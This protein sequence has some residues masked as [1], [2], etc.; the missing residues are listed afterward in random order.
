MAR[1][2][3]SDVLDRLCHLSD[4]QATAG[5]MDRQL[6]ERFIAER[7]ADA[8][9]AL[10]QRH[11]PMVFGVCRRLLREPH[12][13]EDAFQAT[14]LV[15][16]R[17]AA[18]IRK[19]ESV[20]SWLHGVA[21]YVASK[22][23]VEAVRRSRRER[24]RRVPEVAENADSLTWDELR[25]VLDE[26]LGRLSASLRAPLVL[27]YL[28]GQTQD[29]AAR[30]LGWSK[31]TLRRRLERGRRLLR[32]RLAGRGV[33]LSAGLLA[34]LLS[35]PAV[36]PRTLTAGTVKTALAFGNGQVLGTGIPA[37]PVLLAKAALR[38]MVLTKI[39]VTAGAALMLSVLAA[40]GLGAL[41]AAVEKPPVA[42][43]TEAPSSGPD[44]A[45]AKPAPA[46]G[47]PV[48]AFGDPLP[49][50]ALARL[51][52]VRLRHGATPFAIDFS[53][54]GQALASAE[55]DGGVHI[56]ETATGKELLWI[57]NEDVPGG[58][59]AVLGLAYA[60]D[61]KTLA[62]ARMNQPPCLWDVAT[63]KEIRQF[64]GNQ[65]RA[66][67][68]VFS[69][70][71]QSLAYGEG[72]DNSIVRLAEV[73]TGK[74]QHQ[75]QGLKGF[76]PRPAFT[77][78][79]QT[80][81]LADDE[82]IHFFDLATERSQDLPQPD[83]GK[84]AFGCLV[85]SP[86]GKTLAAVSAAKKSIRFVDV[87]T[88]KTLRTIA[89]TGKREQVCGI[90]F[91]PD[92]KTLISG[93]E[94]GFVRFWDMASG[95]KT[96]QFRAHYY[97]VVRLALSRD[98][99]TLATSCN[100]HIGGDHTV[101]LWETATGKSLVRYPGPD[102]GIARLVFSPDSR[103]VATASWE[104][105]V[106]LWEAASGRSLRRWE[107]FGALAF[108]ADGMT[109]IC[110]GWEDGKVHF[111]DLATG[112]ET[113]HF[114]GH[115]KG[116]RDLCLSR[117]GKLL[118]TAAMDQ[119]LRLWDLATGRQ[120][121]DFGGKQKAAVLHVV[122]SP[123]G[124]LLASSYSDHVVR[125]WET[126]SGK[127]VREHV[128]ADDL[129]GLAISPDGQ[130]LAWS[131]SDAPGESSI[132]VRDVATGKEVSRLRGYGD[133]LSS[134]AF[135]PDG[136]S[137]IWGGQHR[138]EMCLF[139]VATGQ[140]R[141]KF[142]GHQGHV[143]CVAFAPN[144]RLMASGG[145]DTCVLIWAAA[146]QRQQLAPAPLREADLD[147][148]WADLAANDAATA[149]RAICTLR[150]SPRQTVRLLE[151]HLKPVPAADAKR[152]AQA[153]HDLDSD[154]FPIRDRA[155]QALA[156]LGEAAEPG[157]RQ[158]LAGKPSA[159][160]RRRVEEF[161]AQVEASAEG[162]RARA[163]EILEQIDSAD[164]RRLLSALAHGAPG[165]RLTREAQAALDRS[166]H[167]SE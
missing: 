164:S 90:V 60:P 120:L 5:M 111:L 84:G 108:T 10:V 97:T 39:K 1:P 24:Q 123:D 44:R 129:G 110:G 166:G 21:G 27:C 66:S 103:Q 13:A 94:D 77:P 150:A 23:R 142:S 52:T 67:W 152:V 76:V 100:D 159:E 156:Q 62:G 158:A 145:S 43:G 25:S 7:E 134:I 28:E 141:R 78:D 106:Y 42:Q 64:G 146:G 95:T 89:L 138:P 12:D 57:P 22:M 45:E 115:T 107:L 144:G 31:S 136:R 118:A 59:G 73:S 157:L 50:D 74:E 65:S 137:L 26:E 127:L 16:A 165:A 105:V 75:F 148:L 82:T 112:K 151:P 131:C 35:E 155:A 85:L 79:G 153:L 124:K 113:R 116:I 32:D 114:E 104:G 2:G 88:R 121:Q 125:V 126:A 83:E 99:R 17:K 92:G 91:L 71:G 162:R 140:L 34:P 68:V 29:E 30:R 86:T 96:R 3:L 4:G 139:E 70:N 49:A 133:P 147:R 143:S 167:A 101:R 102:E 11:G 37:R 18:S 48:D 135:A 15:L 38:S 122:L 163:L 20:A 61:G 154:Q 58:L 6:L 119:F 14:F 69:P 63:G 98:G 9:T 132:R 51:G 128:E 109:L 55:L 149:Y 47:V 81:A 46:A 117:D 33:T 161:L 80:I 72:Q 160:V 36:P 8:F 41:R 130:L 54:D 19:G 87:A 53:P 93:H 40:A 56:W